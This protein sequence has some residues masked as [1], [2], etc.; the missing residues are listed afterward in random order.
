[1]A[2]DGFGGAVADAAVS[3]SSLTMGAGSGSGAAAKAVGSSVFGTAGSV[4]KRKHKRKELALK[5]YI[6]GEEVGA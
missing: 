1:M 4:S 3:S 2:V 6:T 5:F